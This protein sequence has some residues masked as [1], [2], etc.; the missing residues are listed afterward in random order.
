[1]NDGWGFY[2]SGR[3]IISPDGTKYTFLG[4]SVS[5]SSDG[6]WLAVGARG[7]GGYVGACWVFH[8]DSLL[9]EYQV[10]GEKVR[11][12]TCLHVFV[13]SYGWMDLWLSD[14]FFVFGYMIS[15]L[16]TTCT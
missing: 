15:R 11:I 13:S 2:Q 5:L 14:L 7:D 16:C 9:N 3:K 8:R 12:P 10:F 1:M 4:S 6:S